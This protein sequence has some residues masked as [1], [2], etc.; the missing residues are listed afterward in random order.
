[1][2][3]EMGNVLLDDLIRSLERV[4]MIIINGVGSGAS[5]LVTLNVEVSKEARG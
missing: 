5:R 4:I 1:M 2:R 3:I